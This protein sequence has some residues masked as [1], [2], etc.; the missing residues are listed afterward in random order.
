MSGYKL[1]GYLSC[2]GGAPLVLC[3]WFDVTPT[4]S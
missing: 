2:A 1:Y 4:P 3:A